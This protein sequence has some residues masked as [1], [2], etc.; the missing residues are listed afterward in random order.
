MTSTRASARPLD[1]EAS[2]AAYDRWAPIYDFVFTLPFHPG[3]VAATEA[4]AAA[5]GV[6]GKILVVGVG[7]GLELPLLPPTTRV[8]GIDLSRGML[9][10]ARERVARK[11]M[12]HVEALR[13]M[14]ASAIDFADASFDVALAPYVMSVVPRPDRVL[15]EMWRI[16]RP[17]GEL[18]LINHFG[19]ERGWRVG[20][21][22]GMD[23]FAA[24]LGW[25][26]RFPYAAVGDWLAANPKAEL[27]ERRELPPLQL[28]TLLR[29]GK[30]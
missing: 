26:P 4:A 25:H 16:V 15:D 14:D 20:I 11:R 12:R 17:G 9:D 23:S 1:Q 5:A 29:I 3:R 10:V 18:V 7:T 22:T 27:R 8:T 2:D 30:R 28:F 6:N 21:E 24:W 13:E 19:A